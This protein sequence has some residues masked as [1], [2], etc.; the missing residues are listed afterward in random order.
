MQQRLE[1]CAASVKLL[2]HNS[3]LT[4]LAAAQSA[5]DEAHSDED[6]DEQQQA[7]TAFVE[8]QL[9][10]WMEVTSAIIILHAVDNPD[11]RICTS[12]HTAKASTCLLLHHMHSELDHMH[13]CKHHGDAAV[14]LVNCTCCIATRKTTSCLALI[15]FLPEA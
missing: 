5:Y 3:S 12:Q 7:V 11:W 2:K 1:L 14:K 8:A 9:S 10:A 4:P 13:L 6:P 15:T